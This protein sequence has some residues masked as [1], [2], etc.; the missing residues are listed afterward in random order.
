MRRRPDGTVVVVGPLP[1]PVHG[2]ARVTERMRD[3][4]EDRA[5][6]VVVVDTSAQRDDGS[7]LS[8]P[9]RVRRLAAGLL[10]LA[11]ATARGATVYVGGAGGALLWYQ[12]LVLLVARAARVRAVFHH[13]SFGAVREPPA[14]M[15]AL[16]RLGGTDVIHVVL[17]SSMADALRR[18]RPRLRDVRVCSNAALLPEAGA[19][20]S[21]ER[22]VPSHRVLGHLS[23]LSMAKGLGEVVMVFEGL[24]EEEP[25]TRL[26]LAGPPADDEAARLLDDVARRHGRRVEVLG[27]VA[28]DE[29]DAFYRRI[30]VFCFPSRYGHEAEPLV[31]LDALRHGV[32]VVTYD[33]GCLAEVV[34]PHAVVPPDGDYARAVARTLSGA[35]SSSDE[36]ARAFD[37]RRSAALATLDDVVGLLVGR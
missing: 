31:V 8:A 12:A 28:A 21:E 32:P 35:R 34:G 25:G 6:R 19:R 20:H 29:V 7:D 30:D 27:R 37:E 14:A 23:N 24:L 1:P 11:V 16:V 3:V 17:G 36:L 22:P 15:T 18:A 13:H 5:D 10:T 26:L 33:V 2:A 4:L 9:A